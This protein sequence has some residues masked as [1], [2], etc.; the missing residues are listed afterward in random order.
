MSLWPSLSKPPQSPTVFT[1]PP[2]LSTFP[3][4]SSLRTFMPISDLLIKYLIAE[5]EACLTFL[6]G[7][8]QTQ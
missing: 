4:L 7:T 1:N 8:L 5:F 2:G 6:V 3:S